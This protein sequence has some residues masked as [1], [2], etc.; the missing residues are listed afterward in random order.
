MPATQMVAC[1]VF[2]PAVSR[3]QYN[4][5][6]NIWLQKIACISLVDVFALPKPLTAFHTQFIG[7]L[8][9]FDA[10]RPYRCPDGSHCVLLLMLLLLLLVLLLPRNT[11]ANKEDICCKVHTGQ[12]PALGACCHGMQPAGATCSASGAD[13]PI[14]ITEAAIVA[15]GA[16][17]RRRAEGTQCAADCATIGVG[18][19]WALLAGATRTKAKPGDTHIAI[20]CEGSCK[21]RCCRG[22]EGAGLA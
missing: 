9:L 3:I 8:I 2:L 4:M 1:M 6:C 10:A 13:S 18:A 21:S 19:S 5:L 15:N 17:G 11:D 22:S 12:H 20:R 16:W 14:N 7:Y